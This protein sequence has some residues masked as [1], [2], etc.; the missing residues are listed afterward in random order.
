MT[1]RV[2]ALVGEEVEPCY[3]FFSMYWAMGICPV[4]M[5][6]PQA[7]WTV[8]ICIDQSDIWPIH[9]SRILPWPEPKDSYPDDWQA[10]IKSDPTLGF[11]S[12]ELHPGNAII[13]SGSSQY[14]YRDRIKNEA[15]KGFCNLIF[16]HYVPKG[17]NVFTDPENWAEYFGV[18]ELKFK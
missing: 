18:P 5:D 2:S 17:T 12:F 10:Q 6:A 7:K 4:H 8:D 16:L 3:N 14:H 11:Q 9:F 15:G 1:A 13:F